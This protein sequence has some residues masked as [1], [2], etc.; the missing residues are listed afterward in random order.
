MMV[1]PGVTGWM[2]SQASQALLVM[3]SKAPRGTRVTQEHPVLR[4]LQEKGAPPDWACLAPKASVVS[5]EMPD[6]LDPQAFPAPPD[7]QALQDK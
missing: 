2:D 6:Y 3:V 4:A 7:P 5:P 1:S